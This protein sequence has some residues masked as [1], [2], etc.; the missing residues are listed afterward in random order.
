MAAIK[1][2]VTFSE[3][4][5]PRTK[6]CFPEKD[7]D[8]I[9]LLKEL[10]PGKSH[11]LSTSSCALSTTGNCSHVWPCPEGGGV[12]GGA[13]AGHSQQCA[14]MAGGRSFAPPTSLPKSFGG[15]QITVTAVI[16]TSSMLSRLHTSGDIW[17]GWGGGRGFSNSCR[18]SPCVGSLLFSQPSDVSATYLSVLTNELN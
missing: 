1:V 17:K 16:T 10:L 18:M 5:A 12:T 8:A 14:H 6:T 15:W 7:W 3:V 4:D 11:I 2:N 13:S 9:L